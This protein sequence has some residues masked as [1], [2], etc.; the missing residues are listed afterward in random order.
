MATSFQSSIL[1]VEDNLA[2]GELLEMILKA[3][4]YKVVGIAAT[5]EKAM[6]LAEKHRPTVIFMD[7]MLGG[8]LDGIDVAEKILKKYDISVIFLSG[9]DDRDLIERAKRVRPLAFLMKPVIEKQ[10]IVELEVALYQIKKKKE[11]SFFDD[12]VFREELPPKYADLTPAEIRVAS[13]VRKGKSTKEIA[14][15]L[16][17]SGQTIMWHR[18]NIRK[19]LNI[20]NKGE[21]LVTHLLK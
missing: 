13:L 2:I 8:P 7:I 17:V 9:Y 3:N 14:E 1:I 21:N 15:A 6:E 20:S 5:A 19:K 18:K 11:Q 12:D 4:G 16:D 10:I